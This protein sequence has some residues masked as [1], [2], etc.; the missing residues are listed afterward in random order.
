[1]DR[2]IDRE[3]NIELQE[4]YRRGEGGHFQI[5]PQPWYEQEAIPIHSFNSATKGLQAS[6]PATL[7][8]GRR[9]HGQADFTCTGGWTT[10]WTGDGQELDREMD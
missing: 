8:I 9:S 6:I 10:L 4:W 3:M 5:Q 1:M 7:Y 2:E